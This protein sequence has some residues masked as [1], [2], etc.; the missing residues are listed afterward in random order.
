MVRCALSSTAV[1]CCAALRCAVLPRRRCPQMC[2]KFQSA[3]SKAQRARLSRIPYGIA[4]SSV[5][6]ARV[7]AMAIGFQG[8]HHYCDPELQSSTIRKQG[9]I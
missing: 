4:A 6:K 1:L 3:A 8:S 7:R 2:E 9:L 5:R